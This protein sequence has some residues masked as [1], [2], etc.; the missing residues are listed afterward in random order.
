MDKHPIQGGE[1]VA[2]NTH[3]CFVAIDRGIVASN[4]SINSLS[5]VCLLKNMNIQKTKL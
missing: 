5:Y 4:V 1:G 3:I 2:F